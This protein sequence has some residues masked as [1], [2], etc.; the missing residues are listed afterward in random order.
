[1]TKLAYTV[2]VYKKS[3]KEVFNTYINKLTNKEDKD[4][5]KSISGRSFIS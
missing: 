1:M 5:L 2:K 3:I 4:L